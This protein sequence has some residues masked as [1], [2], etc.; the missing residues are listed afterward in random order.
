M[1]R[2][3][4][5]WGYISSISSRPASGNLQ[6]LWGWRISYAWRG[7]ATNSTPLAPSAT[8]ERQFSEI[9]SNLS[10]NPAL[11][12]M[13]L[14]RHSLPNPPVSTISLSLPQVCNQARTPNV[15]SCL[16]A[17]PVPGPPPNTRSVH[18][19]AIYCNFP[20]RFNSGG[21]ALVLPSWNQCG[22]S[23][24]LP[25]FSLALASKQASKQAP[26]LLGKIIF[27][28]EI[29]GNFRFDPGELGAGAYFACRMAG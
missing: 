13:G 4:E 8:W 17:L 1:C 19:G 29:I 14:R 12:R 18:F 10:L 22:L 21:G 24:L 15:T 28:P 16:S 9:I 11:V 3:Q 5:N 23:A 25:H 2:M 6:K 20:F 26:L 7:G 27:E